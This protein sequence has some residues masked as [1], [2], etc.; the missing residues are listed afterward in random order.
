[1]GNEKKSPSIKL[2]ISREL[3]DKLVGLIEMNMNLAIDDE[4]FS[5]TA[6]KIMNKLLTYSIPKVENDME[7][8]DVRFFPSEA[9]DLIWQLLIQ[10]DRKIEKKDYYSILMENR[11]KLRSESK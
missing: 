4:K 2:L 9:S 11:E 8:V 1:M 10:N 5:I 7:Y 6:E 3:F